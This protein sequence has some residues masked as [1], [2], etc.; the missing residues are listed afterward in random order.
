MKN[1]LFKFSSQKNLFFKPNQNNNY[2][3]P[4]PPLKFIK[5][6]QSPINLKLNHINNSIKINKNIFDSQKNLVIKT[7]KNNIINEEKKNVN[8]F[9]RNFLYENYHQNFVT[10]KKNFPI[11]TL[12]NINRINFTN[13]NCINNN[14]E[15]NSKNKILKIKINKKLFLPNLNFEI[16]KKIIEKIKKDE[17]QK[18]YNKKTIEIIDDNNEKNFYEELINIL[19]KFKK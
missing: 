18:I 12:P 16:K 13:N 4:K 14:F 11:T 2:K 17:E 3:I 7:E 15:E 8:N 10:E 9:K 5:Q 19:L 1:K 6:I